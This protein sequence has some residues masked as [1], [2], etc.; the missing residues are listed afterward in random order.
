MLYGDMVMLSK[1]IRKWFFTKKLSK[2]RNLII[3]M[4]NSGRNWS[5]CSVFL[6]FQALKKCIFG[7]IRPV[8]LLQINFYDWKDHY[9]SISGQFKKIHFYR[10]EFRSLQSCS[11]TI[12]IQSGTNNH[13]Q[14]R[15]VCHFL[16]S[17]IYS[18]QEDIV[19]AKN[20]L[21]W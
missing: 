21:I 8:K 18:L 12:L 11:E 7:L 5:L 1:T 4:K 15:G 20:K 9:L 2:S 17:I 19:S 14:L 16:Y 3:L 13:K 10:Y 6:Y